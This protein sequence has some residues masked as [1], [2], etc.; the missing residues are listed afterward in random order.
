MNNQ[1]PQNISKAYDKMF[2]MHKENTAIVNEL[3]KGK[4]P[5]T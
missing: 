1:K 4:H 2:N 5:L 3:L